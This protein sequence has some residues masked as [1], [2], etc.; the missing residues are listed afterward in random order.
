MIEKRV[1]RMKS[2]NAEVH[3]VEMKEAVE[4]V[5]DSEVHRKG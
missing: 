3:G 5:V 4:R 1:V 2:T